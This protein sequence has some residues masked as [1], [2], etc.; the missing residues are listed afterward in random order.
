MGLVLDRGEKSRPRRVERRAF[1]QEL[2]PDPK[3]LDRACD[4]RAQID[5]ALLG[6]SEPDGG[7]LSEEFAQ[8]R[9]RCRMGS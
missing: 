7:C 4:E 3:P 9:R 8:L 5:K 6:N 1:R 2:P